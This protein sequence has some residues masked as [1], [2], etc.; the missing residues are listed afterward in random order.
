M[1]VYVDKMV[2][3]DIGT[4]IA[5]IRAQDGDEIQDAKSKIQNGVFDLQ[6]RQM[7]NGKLPKGIY[8]KN[9]TKILR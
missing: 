9:G 2:N 8:I 3:G 1:K 6:G 7:P 5:P 4:A